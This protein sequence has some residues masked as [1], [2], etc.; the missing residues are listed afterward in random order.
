LGKLNYYLDHDIKIDADDGTITI[1][2]RLKN[3]VGADRV[4]EAVRL[5][6]LAAANYGLYLARLRLM[7]VLIICTSFSKGAHLIYRT[8]A[9]TYAKQTGRGV[10]WP[11]GL[12][13]QP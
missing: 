11:P 2:G 7:F 8:L 1:G 4:R 5:V 6:E 3:L 12:F 9:L 13:V 10:E